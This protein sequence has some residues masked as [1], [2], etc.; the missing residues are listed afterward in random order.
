M[1]FLYLPPQTGVTRDIYNHLRRQE[2]V[3]IR[4]Y[5]FL[6]GLIFFAVPAVLMFSL[7]LKSLPI[8]V[9]GPLI[10]ALIIFARIL[11]HKQKMLLINTQ[12]SKIKGYKLEDLARR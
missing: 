7:I 6:L 1:K 4:I 5:S 9:A 8:I 10:I 3:K 2:K 11:I 12:H